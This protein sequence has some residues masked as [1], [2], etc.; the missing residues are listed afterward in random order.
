MLNASAISTRGLVFFLFHMLEVSKTTEKTEFAAAY[1][2]KMSH[3]SLLMM[4][5]CDGARVYLR[6]G[7]TLVFDASGICNFE[8]CLEGTHRSIWSSLQLAWDEMKSDHHVASSFTAAS[9][10]DITFFLG[11]VRKFRRS[12]KNIAGLKELPIFGIYSAGLL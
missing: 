12:K 10:L 11:K 2:K 9:F 1:L 6:D 8:S 7:R 5:Q 3:S 4:H